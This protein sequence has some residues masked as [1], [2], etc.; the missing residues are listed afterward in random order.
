KIRRCLYALANFPAFADTHLDLAGL[1]ESILS[2]RVG[3]Y[4]TILE[5]HAD[6]IS[7]PALLP[8]ARDLA[9]Q[10]ASARHGRKTVWLTRRGG[11]EIGIAGMLQHGGVTTVEYLD[12]GSV[13]RSEDIQVAASTTPLTVFKALQ[14]VRSREQQATFTDFTTVD[15]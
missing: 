3:E 6:S 7:D 4:R 13:P 1:V 5:E 15:I 8:P 14:L 9:E 12:P 10:L 11:A 2:Q